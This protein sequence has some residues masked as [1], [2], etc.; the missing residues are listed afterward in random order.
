MKKLDLQTLVN[1]TFSTTGC[2]SCYCHFESKTEKQS[3]YDAVIGKQTGIKFKE[4]F[5]FHFRRAPSR[6]YQLSRAM[7]TKNHTTSSQHTASSFIIV[8]PP[9]KTSHHRPLTTTNN[10][11]APRNHHSSSRPMRQPNRR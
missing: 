3:Y 2:L 9:H 6:M 4:T 8:N 1:T 5:N 7:T 10:C 11:H